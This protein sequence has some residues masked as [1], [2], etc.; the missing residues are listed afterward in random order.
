MEQRTRPLRE[1]LFFICLALQVIYLSSGCIL[2][3]QWIGLVCVLGLGSLWIYARNKYVAWVPHLLFLSS[4]AL[5]AI[6]ILM[7][8]QP[9]LVI[10]G[11]G[12]SLITW[13]LYLLNSDLQD[14]PIKEPARR[15]ENRHLQLLMAA[16]VAAIFVAI[17]G[18][19]VTINLPFILL[20]VLILL[21]LFGLDRLWS[22]LGKT[23]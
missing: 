18:R 23:K 19:F 1:Y 5:A 3:G 8:A 16:A 9:V 22:L 12:F 20:V 6:V 11:S 7:G 10:I 17:L 4:L 2:D 14:S 13:D 21:A 15:Y